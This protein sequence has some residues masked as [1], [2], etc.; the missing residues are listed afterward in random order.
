MFNCLRGKSANTRV[1]FVCE[2]VC[3][4]LL[5]M[6]NSVRLQVSTFSFCFLLFFRKQGALNFFF[7]FEGDLEGEPSGVLPAGLLG[8][9]GGVEG[10][11]SEASVVVRAFISFSSSSSFFSSPLSFCTTSAVCPSV[12]KSAI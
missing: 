2:R 1:P 5:V 8:A 10:V 9:V 4:Q 3:E 11:V 7:F 6:N 12:Y